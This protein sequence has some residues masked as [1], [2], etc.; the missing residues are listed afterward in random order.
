MKRKFDTVKA[1]LII[2]V[3]IALTY[4]SVNPASAHETHIEKEQKQVVVKATENNNDEILLLRNELKA[5]RL[6]FSNQ[7]SAVK[8]K[9]VNLN[10]S[11]AVINKPKVKKKVKPVRIPK[12]KL[13]QLINL[14][15]AKNLSPFTIRCEF[16]AVHDK[17]EDHSFTLLKN[18]T[19]S[20]K[21]RYR[22]KPIL[23]CRS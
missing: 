4:I 22:K 11:I 3:L 8:T 21:K 13:K 20:Y 10:K 23:K 1:I 12:Y 7:L 17:D 9:Q 15:Y 16:I 2:I 6:E 14:Y 5:L 19:L 18:E